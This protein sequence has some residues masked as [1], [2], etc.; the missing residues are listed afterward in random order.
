MMQ[1]S[2]RYQNT[3]MCIFNTPLGKQ[4][5]AKPISPI[6]NLGLGVPQRAAL[7]ILTQP[8]FKPD[9]CYVQL[10]MIRTV[11]PIKSSD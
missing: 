3:C 11:K 10:H 8:H 1:A 9:Q 7:W 6:N 5:M 4:V 2:P